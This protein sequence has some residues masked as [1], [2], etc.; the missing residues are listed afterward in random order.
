MTRIIE[1]A[2]RM[3]GGHPGESSKS[4]CAGK[5]PSLI[6]FATIL[7]AISLGE[8][9]LRSLDRRTFLRGSLLSAAAFAARGF[10]YAGNVRVVPAARPQKVIV[11]GAGIAG[12]VAAF[13]K[14]KGQHTYCRDFWG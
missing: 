9:M 10:S 13:G 3:D 8:T 11:V 12:L 7:L 4:G 5:P 1:H 6:R 2:R 14:I